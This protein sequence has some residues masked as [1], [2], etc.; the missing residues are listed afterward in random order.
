MKA[1]V[2]LS[3]CINDS[4]KF[5]EVIA[6]HEG[7]LEQL[8]VKLDK[9]IKACA[10][11]TNGGRKYA[12]LQQLFLSSLW[13]TSS[14]FNHL[15]SGQVGEASG[16]SGHL[17]KVVSDY[18]EIVNMQ[19]AAVEQVSESVGEALAS[20]VRNYFKP[21][22]DNKGYFTKCSSELDNA[23]YKNASVSKS[24]PNDID[25]AICQLD[26]ARKNFSW[27][28]VDYVESISVLQS[29]KKHEV[30]DS[31]VNGLLSYGHFFKT[32]HS[33]NL[34]SES[35]QHLKEIASFVKEKLKESSDLKRSLESRH[36]DINQQAAVDI[37]EMKLKKRSSVQHKTNQPMEIDG[38][39]YKRG[40][41]GNLKLKTWNRRWFF[42]QNNSLCY[43][44]RTGDEKKVLEPDL[45]I[46]MVR[47]L[48]DIDRRYCFELI[49]PHNKH[50]L[51]A[52]N[53]DLYDLWLATLRQRIAYAH[54]NSDAIALTTNDEAKSNVLGAAG[55]NGLNVNA[56]GVP[57]IAAGSDS[58]EGPVTW[59]DSDEERRNSRK[60]L[61]AQ[62]LQIPGN[63][64]CADC[65]AENPEWAS[66]NLGITLCTLC[67]AV[68]RS[69][70]VHVSKVKSLKLDRIEPE[71]LKVMA[72]LGNTLVNSAYEAE[73]NEV[74][75]KR[76]TSSS[77]KEERGDWIRK[78]YI[79]R[80]FTR[81]DPS[82]LMAIS[83]SASQN[84]N[85]ASGSARVATTVAWSVNRLRRRA[86]SL[87]KRKKLMASTGG[88]A[89]PE[90]PMTSKEG[91]HTDE[92]DTD[93]AAS[94]DSLLEAVL[95]IDGTLPRINHPL[96]P[97]SHPPPPPPVPGAT[98][99]ISGD[100]SAD[101]ASVN[102]ENLLFGYS[103]GKHHR[104]NIE[105]DSDQDSTDGE[106]EGSSHSRCGQDVTK[107][108]SSATLTPHNLLYT[109]AR[110][111]NLPVMSHALAMGADTNWRN[112]EENSTV[113]HQ[114]VLSGSV[115]ACEF[116]MLNGSK[117]KVSDAEGNSPLHLAAKNKRTGQVML[118]LKH[119]ADH[120]ILNNAGDSA[121][122]V[123][124]QNCDADTVTILKL[125][126]FKE[127]MKQSG[128]VEIG[129][130]TWNTHLA[131]FDEMLAGNRKAAGSK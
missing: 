14:F 9:V 32:G 113:L 3:E 75:A 89:V 100:D 131:D 83:G 45:R 29:K 47:G 20:F 26:N 39:L 41:G 127:E 6:R 27:A 129:D 65:G 93:T 52:D 46:C 13:E 59:E 123:A 33:R 38:Y 72:E 48:D 130:E 81:S 43:V 15:E 90:E 120:T 71:I 62:V 116:L 118:L 104:A 44:M 55:E 57:G 96:Q 58:T 82:S 124:L 91:Q 36:I 10:A 68:H 128:D 4:P 54:S 31:L 66:V 69:M 19:K 23:L 28:A 42:L 92:K 8:E 50:V 53:D 35:N 70:G 74:I 94:G 86:R 49:S 22:K 102:V 84:P 40:K 51:Q 109:A 117:L 105:L 112:S 111:H 77:D 99:T 11:M 115:M 95:S 63:E 114:A 88:A 16:L 60:T 21:M 2:E 30:L 12:E 24:K 17:S 64:K 108:K 85:G 1:I 18:Q 67:C 125:A 79:A 110:V 101:N 56:D 119:R 121:L 7:D 122:D 87:N 103:L 97:P 34:S 98:S 80:A 5:R 25:E 37:Q 78:K 106:D 61:A 126:A 76:A 73:V 107:A